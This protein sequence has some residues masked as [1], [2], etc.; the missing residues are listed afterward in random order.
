MNSKIEILDAK[1]GDTGTLWYKIKVLE[2]G[3]SKD[4]NLGCGKDNPNDQEEGWAYSAN[5]KLEN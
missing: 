3:C 5:I 4:P 2:Y 1:N